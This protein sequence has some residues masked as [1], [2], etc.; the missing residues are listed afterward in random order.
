MM[1]QRGGKLSW[2]NMKVVFLTAVVLLALGIVFRMIFFSFIAWVLIIVFLFWFSKEYRDY[3]PLIL[4]FCGCVLSVIVI[5]FFIRHAMYD[6]EGAMMVFPLYDALATLFSLLYLVPIAETIG[7]RGNEI[8]MYAIIEGLIIC[9]FAPL[10]K[11]VSVILSL[12]FVLFGLFFIGKAILDA[13][14]C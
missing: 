11:F 3:R 14:M 7:K 12:V 9:S 5:L 2:E 1:Y 4:F 10:L 6:Y 8:E 13:R